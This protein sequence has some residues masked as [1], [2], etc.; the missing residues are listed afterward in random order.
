MD[1]K[2]L[3][4]KI[5]QCRKEIQEL[6]KERDSMKGTWKKCLYAVQE[7]HKNNDPE[8]AKAIA[9]K[10][11]RLSKKILNTENQIATRTLRQRDLQTQMI[12]L[13][14]QLGEL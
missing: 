5:L 14:V 12:L 7:A 10:M 6:Y 4:S 13:K 11:H 2:E 3:I 1:K 8:K 9:F